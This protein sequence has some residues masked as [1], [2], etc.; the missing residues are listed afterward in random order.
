MELINNKVIVNSHK[1]I[2][3]YWNTDMEGD[4]WKGLSNEEESFYKS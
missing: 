2:G 3:D 4:T 1:L